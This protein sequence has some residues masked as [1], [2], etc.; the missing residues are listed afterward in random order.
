MLWLIKSIINATIHAL[1]TFE[2]EISN[3][4]WKYRYQKEMQKR[5]A[6]PTN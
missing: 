2:H 4:I 1:E 5:K 6:F 3:D